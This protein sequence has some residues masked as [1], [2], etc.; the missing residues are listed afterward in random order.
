[1]ISSTVSAKHAAARAI[2]LCI[3]ML[4]ASPSAARLYQLDARLI[5][6]TINSIAWS[7][8]D[9][10][11]AC[12]AELSLYDNEICVYTV[13]DSLLRV[14]WNTNLENDVLSLDWNPTGEFLAAGL[15]AGTGSE[16]RIFRLDPGSQILMLT[17]QFQLGY[18]ARAVRWQPGSSNLFAVGCDCPTGQIRIYQLSVTGIAPV[19][20]AT[21]APATAIWTDALDWS[22]NGTFLA[23][24]FTQANSAPTLRVFEFVPASNTLSCV[25]TAAPGASVA[26]LDWAPDGEHLAVGLDGDTIYRLYIYTFNTTNHEITL[27]YMHPQQ[28]TTRSVHSLDWA[29]DG[30]HLCVGYEYATRPQVELFDYQ[31]A[32]CQLTSNDAQLVSGDAESVRWSPD[33]WYLAAGGSD[34]NA[35]LS[36]LTTTSVDC[37]VDKN[38]TPSSLADGSNITYSISTQNDGAQEA[39]GVVLNDHLPTGLVFIAAQ[40]SQGDCT[41][42]N[43]E[44]TCRLGTIT[45]GNQVTV[46]VQVYVAAGQIGAL[47]NCAAVTNLGN[48]VSTSNNTATCVTTLPDGDGDGTADYEDEDDDGDEMPDVWELQY[49][50]GRT[51]ADARSD[52]DGDGQFN[53][54]EYIGASD[55]Q[56]PS[57]FFRITSL[58]N[59][60]ARQIL[61]PGVTGRL[62]RTEFCSGAV[63]TA[64]YPLGADVSGTGGTITVSD[65]NP[66]SSRS[67]RTMV[68]M[69]N[70]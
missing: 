52:D 70:P 51:N 9:V 57:S 62:Y 3:F 53:I 50:G 23:A 22:S 42:S 28:P 44:L 38:G 61:F 60:T 24:G 2:V 25:S 16:V 29:P 7:P 54:E 69:E 26:A 66:A 63:S 35:L 30:K 43:H 1:M 6:S 10:H 56:S 36:L 48:D 20:S 37:V 41:Y 64:W 5:G 13:T 4:R 46:T 59:G 31:P 14:V 11:L 8:D 33:G 32:G 15:A 45:P 18:D 67:Y 65:T 12:A 58:S 19:T 49:F 40:P 17:N 55:P 34:A 27:C 47:T 68:R 39:R 21:V